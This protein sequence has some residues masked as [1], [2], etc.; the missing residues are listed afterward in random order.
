MSL[1]P[2]IHLLA[3]L[4]LAILIAGV[5]KP[6]RAHECGMAAAQPAAHHAMTRA[7]LHAVG[8]DAGQ[9]CHHTADCCC[10]NGM[11]GCAGMAAGALVPAQMVTGPAPLAGVADLAAGHTTGMGLSLAPALGPPRTGRP[12]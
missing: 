6:A 3:F 12:V 1:R 4:G 10:A 8:A 9:T 5:A 11:A 2:L 7:A